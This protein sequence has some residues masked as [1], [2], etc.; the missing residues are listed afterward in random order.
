METIRQHFNHGASYQNLLLNLF[1]WLAV[2]EDANATEAKA[3]KRRLDHR[4]VDRP[5]PVP[6]P[7]CG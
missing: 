3:K 1:F 7:R 2:D 4:A 6:V 5:K